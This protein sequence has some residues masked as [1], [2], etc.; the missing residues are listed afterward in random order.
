MGLQAQLEP[1]VAHRCQDEGWFDSGADHFRLSPG[2]TGYVSVAVRGW[3]FTGR[4]FK[5]DRW[6]LPL[7]AT[8]MMIM[9]MMTVSS[10][11]SAQV[12]RRA[13][14]V[15]INRTATVSMYGSPQEAAAQKAQEMAATG[16][17]R[18]LGGGV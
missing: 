5:M 14:V 8:M 6:I 17:F 13:R 9:A 3:V 18:H 15:E 1:L 12:L 7:I 16:V 4:K 10:E 11:T 2:I